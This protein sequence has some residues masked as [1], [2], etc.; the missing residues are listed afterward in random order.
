[1]NQM[2]VHCEEQVTQMALLEHGRLVEFAVERATGTT[3]V[4]S[5][6]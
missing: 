5:L 2:I 6:V 1:M 4:G 3:L